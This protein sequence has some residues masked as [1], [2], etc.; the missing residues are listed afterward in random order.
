MLDVLCGVHAWRKLGCN[1]LFKTADWSQSRIPPVESL[2]GAPHCAR[3]GALRT[4]QSSSSLLSED[5]RRETFVPRPLTHQNERKV[6]MDPWQKLC[7]QKHNYGRTHMH[8]HMHIYPYR[9]TQIY[10]HTQAHTCIQA[11]THPHIHIH[12]HICTYTMTYTYTPRQVY[13]DTGAHADAS[14]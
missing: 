8:T 6:C 11:H 2:S 7:A 14:T 3:P 9:E 4:Q 5:H 12:R 10:M 1:Q 13:A